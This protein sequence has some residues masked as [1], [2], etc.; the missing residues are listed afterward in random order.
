MS[1]VVETLDCPGKIWC[2]LIMK[3]VYVWVGRLEYERWKEAKEEEEEKQSREE[4][5]GPSRNGSRAGTG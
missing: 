3:N 2:K 4:A 1:L 5:A